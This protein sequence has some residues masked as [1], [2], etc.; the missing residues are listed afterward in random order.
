MQKLGNMDMPCT[1][2]VHER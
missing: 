1:F 2:E